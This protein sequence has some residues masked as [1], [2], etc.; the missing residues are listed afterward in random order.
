[1]WFHLRSGAILLAMGAVLVQ[2]SQ[3]Y[4]RSYQFQKLVTEEI[5]QTEAFYG[6]ATLHQRILD[7]GRNMNFQ[8]RPDDIHIERVG[9]GYAVYVKYEVPLETRVYSTQMRFDFTTRSSRVM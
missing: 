6:P 7:E 4:M 3:P 9:R 8:I 2:V 5:E 1:M